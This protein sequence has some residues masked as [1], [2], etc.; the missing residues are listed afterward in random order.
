MAS[1]T[2]HPRSKYWF[3]CYRDAAGK[4]HFKSTKIEHAPDAST[5]K[6]RAVKASE[7]RRLAK[8]IAEKL[9]EAERGNPTENHLREVLAGISERLTTRKLDFP[10]VKDYLLDWLEARNLSEGTATRYRKPITAFIDSLGN[11]AAL[12]ITTV[13][14]ADVD[15]FTAARLKAGIAPSTVSVDVKAL[16]VPFNAATRA[17]LLPWNPVARAAPIEAV[18]EQ[19]HPFTREEVE[20]LLEA[21]PSEEWKTVVLL[22]GLAGLRFS[23]AT[24]LRWENVDLFAGTIA[25]RPKK[26]S[27]QKRDLVLPMAGRLKAHLLTLTR[28]TDGKGFISPGLAAKRTSGKSGLSVAFGKIMAAA[29]IDR[30]T[31]EAAGGEGRIFNRK[32]FHSLRH[33][34]ISELE[35]RGV[36][37]D[38]RMKLS[39]HTTAGAHGRY[40]HTELETLAR[41]V[42]GL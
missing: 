40:V 39:G 30:G 31:L 27:R 10:T 12:P 17:G 11:R 19:R 15:S 6:A 42:E 38:L 1:I 25:F 21:C 3:A 26:T 32:S 16:N 29:G 13:T 9:E 8:E 14:P 2:I 4:Q 28:P 20:A 41:A 5:A 24:G 23:D 37:P 35:R 7:N 22:G 34:F 36:A 18:K 33:H